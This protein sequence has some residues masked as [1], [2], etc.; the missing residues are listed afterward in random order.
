MAIQQL[1]PFILAATVSTQT[2]VGFKPSGRFEE[3]LLK[4]MSASHPK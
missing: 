4:I 1:L 3:T 2:I